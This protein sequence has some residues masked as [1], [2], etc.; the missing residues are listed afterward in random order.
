[1]TQ[2]FVWRR[3]RR[4]K[5]YGVGEPFIKDNVYEKR[6]RVWKEVECDLIDLNYGFIV[7]GKPGTGK[8]HQL[9]EIKERLDEKGIPYL[10]CAPTH[11]AARKVGGETFHNIFGMNVDT[12][13]VCEKAMNVAKRHDYIF[14][15]ECSMLTEEMINVLAILKKLKPT[16]KIGLFG[17]YAQLPPVET[18]DMI[19]KVKDK[20]N[21]LIAG[22]KSYDKQKGYINDLDES[23][24]HNLLKECKNR[25]VVSGVEFD[26][27]CDEPK[28]TPSLDRLDNGLGHCKGNVRFI[29]EYENWLRNTRDYARFSLNKIERDYKNSMVLKYLCDYNRLELTQYWRATRYE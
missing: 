11:S 21:Q 20:I 26:W 27:F 28:T 19:L 14:I 5:L 23:F 9:K 17:D 13:K 12:G 3:L 24:V 4:L 7:N 18:N 29:T 6:E 8:S 2:N 22:C 1:M 15:D 25:S 16:I 10:V